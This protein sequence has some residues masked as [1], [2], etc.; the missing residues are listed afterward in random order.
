[1][2]IL[3]AAGNRSSSGLQFQRIKE[4]IS[5]HEIKL[6][7]FSSATQFVSTIDFVL[8]YFYSF[9]HDRPS[10][11]R[12]VREGPVT[13][14]LE[15]YAA[16]IA[17]FDP[18]LIIADQEPLTAAVGKFLKIPIWYC[19]PTHL[20][21][22]CFIRSQNYFYREQFR[23]FQYESRVWPEADR[24]FIYSPFSRL[25]II[26][27]QKGFEWIEPYSNIKQSNV[28]DLN[29]AFFSQRESEVFSIFQASKFEGPFFS[30][31]KLNSS[32]IIGYSINDSEYNSLLSQSKNV[33]CA[34]ETS[35][36]SDALNNNSNIIVCPNVDDYETVIN[37]SLLREAEIGRELG[38][39]EL[40]GSVAVDEVNHSLNQ[41]F[42][43]KLRNNLS[44]QYLHEIINKG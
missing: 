8:D 28:K 41:Q 4:H 3:Y 10:Y 33:F 40:M 15:T 18:D 17:E 19:S 12:I 21:D 25:K 29:V 26:S 20:M 24:T 37:A 11:K 30:N 14:E 13:K 6:A 7:A 5:N 2:K 35:V 42:S 32:K 23:S 16:S 39:I 43:Y 36:I 34:G 38:Q 1:M 31:S 22:G 9:W 44:V 27:L